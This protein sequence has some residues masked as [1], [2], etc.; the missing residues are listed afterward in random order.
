[1]IEPSRQISKKAEFLRPNFR[2]K[3]LIGGHF[4]SSKAL[5]KRGNIFVETFEIFDV[6]WNFSPFLH[7]WKLCE[8]RVYFL[9]SKK[10][11]VREFR[12]I[13]N[14]S[15]LISVSET[16]F[17]PL[18]IREATSPSFPRLRQIHSA[19]YKNLSRSWM[20]FTKCLLLLS[21]STNNEEIQCF[22][23]DVSSFAQGLTAYCMDVFRA[24]CTKQFSKTVRNANYIAQ[25]VDMF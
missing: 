25:K 20:F 6:F 3:I 10:M 13:F 5:A 1:M 12:N 16:M 23:N 4:L 22:L 9:G 15:T 2:L 24:H 18:P 7:P 19:V 14:F 17:L 8:S 11:F 21:F